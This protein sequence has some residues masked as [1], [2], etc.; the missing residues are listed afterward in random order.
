MENPYQRK[1]QPE[2]IRQKILSSAIQLAAE[3]GVAGVSIQSVATLAGITKGGVFHHFANKKILIK[4]MLAELILQLDTEIQKRIEQD[5]EIYGC[6]TRAYIEVTLSSEA[7]GV[8]SAW[9]ALCMTVITDKSFG[10][11]WNQ[12]LESRLT[13]HAST[14]DFIE[15]KIL[16]YA[17]DGAWFIEGLAPKPQDDYKVIKHELLLRSY[18][19]NLTK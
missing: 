11:M 16:R 18:P 17:A 14:D 6:F 9:S 8:D 2:I 10:E 13:Q 12:W 15:L 1:K 19:I 3:N 7:I 5:A 4:A